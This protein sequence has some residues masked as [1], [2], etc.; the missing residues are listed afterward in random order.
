M[1]TEDPKHIASTSNINKFVVTSFVHTHAGKA[2]EIAEEIEQLKEA[3]NAAHYYIDAS[4][5]ELKEKNMTRSDA[6]MKARILRSKLVE[7]KKE[8]K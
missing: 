4:D 6:L 7:A 2:L 5:E 8:N 1:M 3:L